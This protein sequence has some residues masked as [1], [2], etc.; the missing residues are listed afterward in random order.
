MAT[1]VHNDEADRSCC[2]LVRLLL[3]LYLLRHQL[4]LEVVDIGERG[5]LLGV[6]VRKGAE[7]QDVPLKHALKKT[8]P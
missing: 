2:A 1:R 3:R 7:C 6:A 4:T 5:Q 8:N